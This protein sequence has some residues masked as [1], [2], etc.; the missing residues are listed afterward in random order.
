MVT[1][2]NTKCGIAEFTRYFIEATNSKVNYL[3]YPNKSNEL[4][5]ED[6][7]FVEG[8]YWDVG[9]VKRL[10]DPLQESEADA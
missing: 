8:R 6:E 5:R 10:L 1:T 3:I 4:I 7:E 2:W 9:Q